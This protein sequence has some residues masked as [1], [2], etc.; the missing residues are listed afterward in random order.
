M[1]SLELSDE[2]D[3][4]IFSASNFWSY[5]LCFIQGSIKV[6]LDNKNGITSKYQYYHDSIYDSMLNI[7]GFYI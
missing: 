3:N 7:H 5:F 4:Y 1:R 2:K 6:G